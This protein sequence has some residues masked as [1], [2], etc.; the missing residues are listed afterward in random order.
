MH[1]FLKSIISGLTVLIVGLFVTY[2]IGKYG[3]KN[4][5]DNLIKNYEH[6]LLIDLSLFLTGFFSF[7]VME[8]LGFTKIYCKEYCSK[9]IK[10]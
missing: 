1:F 5:N 10:S 7:I 3:S 2:I 4:K 9:I 8:Y 6:Q